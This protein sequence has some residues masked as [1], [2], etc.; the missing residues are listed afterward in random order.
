MPPRY[1]VFLSLLCCAVFGGV[2][3]HHLHTAQTNPRVVRVAPAGGPIGGMVSVPIELVSQGDE[4]AI[5]FSLTFNAAVL[6]NP[7]ALLGA[8]AAGATIN[9]N[10]GQAA[11]GRFG[12]A[13][14]FP[15]N[16]KFAAGVRQM[17]IVTFTIS[18]NATFGTTPVGFG[19]QPVLRE[20]S[21]VN[22]NAVTADFAAGVVT[23]TKGYEADVSPRPD[24]DNNGTVTVTDWVQIGKFVAGVDTPAT[25][26]EFQRADCAPRDTLGDGRISITDWTQAGRYSAGLDPIVPAGGPTTPIVQSSLENEHRKV[27]SGPSSILRGILGTPR[28]PGGNQRLIIEV[29]AQGVENAFG[30][31]LRFNAAQWR[32]I[33]ATVSGAPRDAILHV[34]TNQAAGGNIGIALALPAGHALR[35]GTR[36]LLVF[37]FAPLPPGQPSSLPLLTVDFGDVPVLRETANINAR[38]VPTI[39]AIESVIAGAARKHISGEAQLQLARRE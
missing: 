14:A 6:G 27:S 4:N 30:F 26:N 7:Q 9:T 21:D 8:D 13:L 5:G 31:S 3:S 2:A 35:A 1:V 25:G 23:V 39:Y 33:S 20:L 37:E 34:N 18:P 10:A 29:D 19:D 17:V 38:P 22:A 12:I 16:Q 24:G 36:S 15:A 28:P 11:Q 32:F